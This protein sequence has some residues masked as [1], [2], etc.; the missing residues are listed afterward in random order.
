[1]F[2]PEYTGSIRPKRALGPQQEGAAASGAA[3][4]QPLAPNVGVA[5]G[6][7]T[8]MATVPEGEEPR[9]CP[10]QL[11]WLRRLELQIHVDWDPP[12]NFTDGIELGS[13]DTSVF[14]KDHRGI[15]GMPT[16]LHLGPWRLLRWP[17][18]RSDGRRLGAQLTL[19]RQ[20]WRRGTGT[21]TRRV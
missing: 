7:D 6:D 9:P 19:R 2:V 17:R 18:P 10:S 1:M 5:K 4:K 14:T 21:M 20:R 16:R 3:R 12:T 11:P 8:A 13:P 15:E